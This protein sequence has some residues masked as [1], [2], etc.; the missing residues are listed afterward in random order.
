MTSLIHE[1]QF[2]NE[3]HKTANILFGHQGV[4]EKGI[5]SNMSRTF[6]YG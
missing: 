4:N 3:V 6:L 5:A 1:N 2:E